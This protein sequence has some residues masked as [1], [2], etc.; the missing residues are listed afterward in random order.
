LTGKSRQA[1][2]AKWAA[3][4]AGTRG[5][6]TGASGFLG[7][8]LLRRLPEDVDVA[9]TYGTAD[10]FPEFAR[11][12]SARVEPVRIDLR[13]ER[14]SERVSGR[15]DWLAHL[16]GQPPRG[17][18]DDPA[19]VVAAIGAI[20]V[21]AVRR[22]EV[23]NVV[24]ASSGTVYAGL[25]GE[26]HP[27]RVPAPR[28]AYAIAKLAAERLLAASTDAPTW[29]VRIFFPY[30]PGE[31]EGRLIRSLVEA[32]VR[33]RPRVELTLDPSHRVDPMWVEDAVSALLAFAALPGESR[34]VDLAAGDSLLVE[35][36]AR[37]V[38]SLAAEA[39]GTEAPDV[40]V[41]PPSGGD[42]LPGVTSAGEVDRLLG[43]PRLP[44]AEGVSRYARLLA[45]G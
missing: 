42:W 1:S 4:L 35:E 28:S 22:L 27:G 26:I 16:A 20:G 44:L 34:P 29:H 13:I 38:T 14:L 23:A 8:H 18:A 39:V 21:N 7:R 33:G 32:S 37:K 24:D 31:R 10:D 11:A 12:C 2:S 40:V 43:L 25:T 15:F 9:A 3:R 30:G 45:A 41:R 36:L 19:G 5:A 6:V 17:G